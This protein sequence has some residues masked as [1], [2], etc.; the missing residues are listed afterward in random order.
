MITILFILFLLGVDLSIIFSL[1][2]I[3]IVVAL[4]S[5]LLTS[6]GALGLF[7]ILSILVIIIGIIVWSSSNGNN[8]KTGDLSTEIERCYA[9]NDVFYFSYKGEKDSYYKQRKVK[10]RWI[11]KRRGRKYIYAWDLDRQG[12]RHFRFDRIRL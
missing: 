2:G 1:I 11:E 8:E 9:N 12:H 5:Q 3:Y 6:I 4:G 7:I 10:V